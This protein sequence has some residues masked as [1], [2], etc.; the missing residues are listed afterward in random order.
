MAMFFYP[1]IITIIASILYLVHHGR[2]RRCK[3]PL[4]NDWPILG[5]LPQLLWNFFQIHD[6]L[7]HTIN[8][9]G[10]TAEFMGP[11]FTKM[12]Y[13]VTRDP[14]NAHH[15]L[16]KR[17]EDYVKGADFREVF[18]A[19]GDGI[20]A[21]DSEKWKDMRSLFHSLFKHKSFEVLLEKTIQKKLQN[22][23]LP[24]LSNLCE[25]TTVDLQ[26]LFCRFTFDNISSLGLGFDPN[27]LSIEFPVVEAK[28][29]FDQIQ[30]CI[31][32]RHGVPRS[33]WKLQEWLQIG[34]EKKMAK[35]CRVFDNFLCTLIASKLEE[36]SERETNNNHQ[37]DESVL[38]QFDSLLE[39]VTRDEARRD[40]KFLRDSA[41][42][43]FVAGKDTIASALTWFFWLVATHPLVEA[44]ILE[45]I[46]EVFGAND[47]E[48]YR[49]LGMV[50]AKKLVYLHGALCEVLRLFPP[51]PLERK[52]PMKADV[53]PS[54][55]HVDSDTNI[56][57][58]FYAMG[59]SEEIWGKDCLEFKPER[60]ISEK[61][62]IIHVPSYKFIS[63]NAGPRTCL[64]KD[65]S[66]IQMKMVTSAILRHYCVH[67]VEDHPRVIPSLSI[68]LLMKNG[69]KVKITKRENIDSFK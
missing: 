16:S 11:W 48:Q 51:I 56:I 27:S 57:F 23:L 39:V 31:L 46:R 64:G 6:F 19:F 61:G 10:G 41:F 44:K 28:K 32:Y 53:L 34:E 1:A 13:L 69:L 12:N 38:H 2:R 4:S 33:V 36:L 24:I 45:E 50:D 42:N 20:V 54:G 14:M 9:Q 67:L 22:S 37:V 58:S 7:A 63:F 29:A 49:I 18:A 55:H 40:E 17:F 59:R 65:M 21:A 15:I 62:G 66:F 47:G 52:Q 26:D 68:A 5:M 3:T 8:K 30:E 43:L 25:E 60:W 35:A